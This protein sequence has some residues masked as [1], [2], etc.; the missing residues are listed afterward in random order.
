MDVP[1]WHKAALELCVGHTV[2]ASSTWWGLGLA[3]T[4]QTPGHAA[5]P[6][7]SLLLVRPNPERIQRAGLH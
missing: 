2:T 5:E 7:L 4:C 6:T 3:V 1:Q